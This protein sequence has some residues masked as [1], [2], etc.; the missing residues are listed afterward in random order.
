[1]TVVNRSLDCSKNSGFKVTIQFIRVVQI[2]AF[3]CRLLVQFNYVK[4]LLPLAWRL[5]CRHFMLCLQVDCGGCMR[6]CCVKL[7]EILRNMERW[8]SM[9][10]K[11]RPCLFA[12][13]AFVEK[14]VS[15]VSYLYCVMNCCCIWIV[16]LFLQLM[17]MFSLSWTRL[18]CHDEVFNFFFFQI[19]W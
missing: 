16:R 2:W 9:W 4:L 19:V 8:R 3:L 18:Q 14:N 13:I 15:L 1:M 7:T 17:Q 10:L 6:S 11:L 5:S 12:D